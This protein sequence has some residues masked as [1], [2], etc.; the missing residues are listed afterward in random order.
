MRGGRGV[1]AEAADFVLLEHA[2]GFGGI[3]R[4]L[5]VGGIEDVAQLRRA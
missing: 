5:H 1:F 4:A 2:E 3:I